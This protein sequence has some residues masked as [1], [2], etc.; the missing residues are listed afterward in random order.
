MA[1]F[2]LEKSRNKISELKQEVNNKKGIVE[3]LKESKEQ[4]IAARAEIEG[5]GISEEYKE[6]IAKALEVKR[7]QI[8]EEGE[9]IGSEIGKD[10]KEIESEMQ[11]VQEAGDSN[12]TQQKSVE[13]KKAILEKIGM[14]GMLDVAFDQL[15][16]EGKQIEATKESIIELRKEA[17]DAAREADG[18]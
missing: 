16:N 4:V 13:S 14:G 17:E 18:L 9:K 8:S 1:G 7:E 12:A 6:V 5:A 3:R 2:S 10:L 15:S 11:E